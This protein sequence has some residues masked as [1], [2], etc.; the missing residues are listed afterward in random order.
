MVSFL[1]SFFTESIYLP[2]LFLLFFVLKRE[3]LLPQCTNSSFTVHGNQKLY[4]F[5]RN[6]NFILIH[7]SGTSI[8]VKFSDRNEHKFNSIWIATTQSTC[9]FYKLNSLWLFYCSCVDIVCLSALEVA[10]VPNV[11]LIQILPHTNCRNIIYNMYICNK[12]LYKWYGINIHI[13]NIYCV[14]YIHI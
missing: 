13:Y 4:P 10:F 3:L 14:L 12:T 9:G 8:L 2:V 6:G 5:F 7:S 11:N 1:E